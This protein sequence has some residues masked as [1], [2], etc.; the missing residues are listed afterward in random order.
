MS[1]MTVLEPVGVAALSLWALLIALVDLRRRKIPNILL[2]VG[3]LGGCGLGLLVP[4]VVPA[5]NPGSVIWGALIG[6]AVTL[7]GYAMRK[8]GA[9]DAKYAAVAG[10]LS[11]M[12]YAGTL[13]LVSGAL[14]G[15]LSLAM[16]VS[17]PRGWRGGSVP[18]GVA[19]SA[20][21]VI[22]VL[23]HAMGV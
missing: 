10:G 14:L 18:A 19:L 7:P 2:V 9:G 8:L 16:A 23:R 12:G 3:I 4:G 13:W 20:A 11:G 5:G 21:F 15:A 22:V 1:Q 6:L 17:G